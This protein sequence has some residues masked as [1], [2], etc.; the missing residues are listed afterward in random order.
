MQYAIGNSKLG[1]KVIVVSRPVGL[2]CPPTCPYLANICYAKAT[3]TLFPNSRVAAKNNVQISANDVTDMIAFAVKTK[4]TVR[5]HERGDFC[6]NGKIDRR[7]LNMWD[8]GIRNSPIIPHIWAYTHKYLKSI[9][10]LPLTNMYASV[11]NASD[12][13]KAAKAGFN[14][15]AWCSKMLGK[16]GGNRK[17]PS[18]LYVPGLGKT[19]V[20]PEQRFGRKQVTCDKCRFCIEGK[21]NVCFLEH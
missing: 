6:Y 12:I 14:L 5:I 18:K 17:A 20:C 16:N 13:K 3:E 10:S 19:L 7:Y 9:A 8:I 2:T 15:F 11:H 1:K 21:G 4:R